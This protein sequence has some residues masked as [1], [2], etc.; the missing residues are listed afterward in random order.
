MPE[1]M[2]EPVNN[3]FTSYPEDIRGGLLDLRD[4]IRAAADNLGQ[5]D[6]LEETL[7]WGEPS[8][9]LPGGTTLRIDWKAKTPDHYYMFFHCQTRLV[10]SFKE[11]YGELFAY[12]GNR[13]LVFHKSDVLPT[14]S[15]H[16]CILAALQYQSRKHLP[17]LGL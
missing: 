4:L 9:I 16:Q 3:R 7:K 12:Q 2:P 14:E 6:A 17:L 5:L 8:Y 10:D 1:I 15:L 13:A 11:R